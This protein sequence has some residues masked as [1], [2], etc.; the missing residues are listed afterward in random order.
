MPHGSGRGSL[1]EFGASRSAPQIVGLESGGEVM[2]SL[3][4]AEERLLMVAHG[5]DFARRYYAIVAATG[6]G[7]PCHELPRAEIE[8]ALMNTGRTFKFH[9]KE[10]F[11]AIREADSAGKLGLNLA[12][13]GS[14]EFI[15]VVHS[16]AGHIGPTYQQLALNLAERYF[17]KLIPS[18]RYPR[19]WYRDSEELRRVL[20]EGLGLY[21]ELATA[22]RGCGLLKGMVE[23]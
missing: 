11:Y 23:R 6:D 17:P 2:E 10:T 18:P 14:I 12:F 3:E 15:L 9:A 5:L 7:Q 13:T 21:E 22:I 1:S 16:P 4:E 19:P 8:A 20:T